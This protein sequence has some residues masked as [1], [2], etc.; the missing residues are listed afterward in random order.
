MGLKWWEKTVEYFFI[1]QCI[2]D[3]MFIAP[4]DGKQER[5]GDSIFSQGNNWVLIEFKKNFDSLLSEEDKFVD[6]E[7]AKS[8]FLNRDSH[9]F[10]IY[11]GIFEKEGGECEFD[12]S[13]VTY[14]SR[15]QVSSVEAMLSAGLTFEEFFDY[16]K[17]FTSFKKVKDGSSGSVGLESYGLVAA[18]N[19]EN[20]IVECMSL[21]ELGNELGLDL[22]QEIDPVPPTLT[23]KPF[24]GMSGPGGR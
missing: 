16:V 22:S 7:K 11:G 8:N 14:F 17:E 19:S 1:R 4:L 10:L 20:Q 3:S 24:R 12:V 21:A 18:I 6:Y 5:A 13:A 2:S 15:T 23:P 9:H